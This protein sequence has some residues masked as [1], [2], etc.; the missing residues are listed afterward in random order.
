MVT[1]FAE[2]QWTGY[3]IALFLGLGIGFFLYQRRREPVTATLPVLVLLGLVWLCDRLVE[4]PKEGMAKTID[5]LREAGVQ[6]DWNRVSA[7][8]SERFQHGQIGSKKDLEAYF[9]RWRNAISS[10]RLVAWGF[11]SVP[12]S[13]D[14]VEFMFK[15]EGD[16]QMYF[17][18]VRAKM[19]KSAGGWKLQG[20]RLFNPVTDLQE[21][22]IK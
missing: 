6:K 18:K 21:M 19:E 12:D 13:N 3:I 1:W 20:F 14:E 7:L 5:S 15:A 17:A 16:G 22:P 2:G 4:T 10:P 8:L 11:T 9:Q